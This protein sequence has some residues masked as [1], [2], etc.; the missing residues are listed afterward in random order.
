MN[1]LFDASGQHIPLG[2]KIG[3]GGEGAVYDLPL[4][5]ADFVAKVYHQPLPTHRQAKLLAMVEC[6]TESLRKI[7][8]WPVD[9]L[10]T[11]LRGG[12]ICG[13][14]MPKVIG[15]EPI[16]HLYGPGHRK[17]QFPNADWGF[18][19]N[20][21]RNVAAAFDVIHAH[22]HVIADVNQNNIVVARNSIVKLID[23]DSFQITTSA[24]N[25]LC[26][27]GVG[28]FTPPELQGHS[29]HGVH[30]TRNHDNFG[31]AVLIFHLLLMGRHPYSGVYLGAE[32]MPVE[33]A[34]QEF[35]FAFGSNAGSKK[36]APPPNSVPLNILP[37]NIAWLF[38]RAFSE[39]SSY[40]KYRPT[41]REWLTA[42]DAL[43]EQLSTCSQITSHQYFDELNE[44]PWCKL[45]QK[46]KIFFFNSPRPAS[47]IELGPSSFD[48]VKVW[49]AINAVPSPGPA[50]PINPSAFRV[51]PNPLPKALNTPLAIF[52]SK[53]YHRELRRREVALENS[54][55]VF[56]ARLKKWRAEAGDEIFNKKF[57]ELFYLRLEYERL[58][59][60]FEIER[61]QIQPQPKQHFVRLLR[62]IFKRKSPLQDGNILKSYSMNSNSPSSSKSF[63]D[64]N[65][66]SVNS[67][68]QRFQL[69]REQ[70]ENSLMQGVEQ[71][72]RLHEDALFLRQDL[73]QP[74]MDAAQAVAQAEADLRIM[75]RV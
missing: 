45:E 72:Q 30:R 68:V 27:V 34:I 11:T 29:F 64:G 38:E 14:I 32:E 33:K 71:L 46:S 36:M 43:K 18:L 10:Y 44:C 48:L 19:V 28:H 22:N 63:A 8:A 42:L 60:D 26:E 47:P 54:R 40:T 61:D 25:Y 49:E 21:A 74:L 31:L 41:A 75:R 58:M 20:T 23:C 16:H 6:G 50:P 70:L 66:D 9:A 55:T 12:A 57:R 52:K 53:K 39:E 13:F 3:A 15:Y 17:Q 7:A 37:A 35:R 24:K 62:I 69:R 51:H 65:N 4:Y 73:Y 67:L 2:K 5:G 56:A 1:D 59:R